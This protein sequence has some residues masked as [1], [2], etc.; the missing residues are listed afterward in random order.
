MKPMKVTLVGAKGALLERI[1]VTYK[2]NG[3]RKYSRCELHPPFST[4][5]LAP[6]DCL[7]ITYRVEKELP[8]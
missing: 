6:G 7:E 2:L 8:R 3:K 5:V 4:D 1:T